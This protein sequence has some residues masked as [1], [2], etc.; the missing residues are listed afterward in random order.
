MIYFFQ[1]FYSGEGI[2]IVFWKLN[3][4]P[5]F[6]NPVK[7]FNL[8]IF[9]VSLLPIWYWYQAELERKITDIRATNRMICI[10]SAMTATDRRDIGIVKV[11]YSSL[12]RQYLGRG[13]GGG[14][15]RKKIQRPNLHFS[16]AISSCV[17]LDKLLNPHL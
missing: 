7:C 9:C 15:H 4:A 5:N 17:T 11:Y 16:N 1:D 12:Q 14:G 6:A 2:S 10:N 3:I 8:V 13:G